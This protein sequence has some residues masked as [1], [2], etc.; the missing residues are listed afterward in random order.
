MRCSSFIKFQIFFFF[1]VEML[2]AVYMYSAVHMPRKDLKRLYSL[3]TG[4]HWGCV[5]TG[6]ECWSRGAQCCRLQNFLTF[7]GTGLGFA[8]LVT[9]QLSVDY[10]KKRKLEFSIYPVSQ[11]STVVTGSYNSTST[12][13]T[14][15]EH[16]IV[17]SW[18]LMRPFRV[19]AAKLEHWAP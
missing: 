11:V 5:K 8:S 6:R 17:P 16:L 1:F 7:L 15:L 19:S 4:W 10:G 14:T 2:K 18:E 3:T 9:K 13:T 12:N